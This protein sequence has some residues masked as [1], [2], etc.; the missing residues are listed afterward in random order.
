[1]YEPAFIGDNGKMIRNLLCLSACAVIL[2]GCVCVSSTEHTNK[3][4]SAAAN[5]RIKETAQV[6]R[7]VVLFKLKD[8]T[9]EEQIRKIENDS[10]A[11]ASKID[12]IYDFEWGT[13]VSVENLQQDFTHCCFF[14]FLSE[15]D[16]D[17]YL[18][19]PVHTE[20]SAQLKPYLD[21]LLV[22]DYWTKQ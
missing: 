1:V 19:H 20:F 14:T 15:A 12:Q 13:D 21:K 6:L 5:K 22:L 7:H 18:N 3:C 8:G 10:C 9:T 11:M 16:R 17:T 2:T 4:Q